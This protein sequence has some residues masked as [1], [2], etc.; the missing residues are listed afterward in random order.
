MDA[1]P[2]PT[3]ERQKAG[4]R[5]IVIRWLIREHLG[6]VFVALALFLSAGRTDWAMGWALVLITLVW[7]EANAL[8]IIPRHPELL[9]ER[10]G[11]RKGAQT[12]D[13]VLM[14]FVGLA[15]LARLI[16]AGLDLRFGWTTG[17]SFPLQITAL[18]VA[19][20]GYGLGVWA[21]AVNTFFSQIVRIQSERGH[22]V[23]TNGPYRFVRH[24]GYTGVILF[25]LAVPIMLG[26]WWALAVGGFIAVLM[27]TRTVLEDRTLQA[28]L[29]GYP[30]YAQQVKCRLLPGVW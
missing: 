22:Q 28:E 5:L 19:A 20:L 23:V 11:P 16:I 8:V 27:I 13:T 9:A 12:W 17:I 7:V 14:S 21:T 24:P 3:P 30:E 26:S 10:M 25:E 6:V 29:D 2:S 15:V 18:V 4:S 1:N